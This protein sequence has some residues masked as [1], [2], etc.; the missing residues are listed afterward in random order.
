MLGVKEEIARLTLKNMQYEGKSDNVLGEG[1]KLHPQ[2][3]KRFP[4]H[5]HDSHHK[6]QYFAVYKRVHINNRNIYR[7]I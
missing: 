5:D 3:I 2:A 1:Q 6:Q 7:T 4:I